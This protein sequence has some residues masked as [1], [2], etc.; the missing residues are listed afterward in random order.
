[1]V[2]RADFE[3]ALFFFATSTH[4]QKGIVNHNLRCLVLSIETFKPHFYLLRRERDS[5]PR[6]CYPQRFSRPP[7]STTLPSLQK[8]C[9]STVFYDSLC[10]YRLTGAKVS[11]IY[12]LHKRDR[13]YFNFFTEK[14]EIKPKIPSAIKNYCTKVRLWGFM[15]NFAT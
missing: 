15:C 9:M 5:N 6:R 13:D 12:G 11:N 1:M 10:C 4:I 14:H 3:S 2:M 7:Q 8:N